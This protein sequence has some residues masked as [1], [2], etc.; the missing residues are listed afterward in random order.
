[1]SA[2]LSSSEIKSTLNN[3]SKDFVLNLASV[4][5]GAAY[6]K[7]EY[8]KPDTID[9]LVS[10]YHSEVRQFVS[11]YKM[12]DRESVN[13]RAAKDFISNNYTNV[14]R[15]QL[16]VDNRFSLL[17]SLYTLELEG[18]LNYIVAASRI[19]DRKGRR[20]YFIDRE[21]PISTISQSLDDFH[22]YWNS[23]RPYPLLIRA[24]E[25]NISDG[26]TIFEIFKEQ[27]L[28]TRDE[29]GFRNDAS[30]SDE[31]PS[32]PKITT[33]KHYPI[34]KIRF[35]ITTEG[36]QTIF[37]FTDNYENGWKNILESLFKRTIDD[38]EIY[39]DLQR[40]KSKVATEIEQSASNA[41]ADSESSDQSVTGIIEDGIKRKIESAK[42]RVDMMEL[43]DEEKAGLKDRLDSIELGG[44]EL[45]GDSSTGTNQFRLVAN[46]EDAYSSFDTMEQTFEEILNKA[47]EENMKFVI[48]IKGRPIA[49]DSGTW[50]LLENGRISDENK[51]ALEAFFGQI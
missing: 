21:I 38:E 14:K 13:L 19:Y 17:L 2:P 48:K 36:G 7:D 45:R 27:G 37:T 28:R 1:M 50:D 5:T 51:R 49:I 15:E 12:L 8:T 31:Y 6:D 39:N 40:H 18:E 20:S 35:E 29:F 3:R 9:E 41:T 26:G 25:S 30:G 4:L 33:R 44:S 34:K 24:Y 23:E 22:D 16:D 47:S 42:G 46:L 10:D 32:K 43:T 11:D